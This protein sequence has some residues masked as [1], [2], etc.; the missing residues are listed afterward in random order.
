MHKYHIPNEQM[1][2]TKWEYSTNWR[3]EDVHEYCQHICW[4]PRIYEEKRH[5]CMSLYVCGARQE[6]SRETSVWLRPLLS[7]PIRGNGQNKALWKH[8]EWNQDFY[9]HLWDNWGVFGAKAMQ[10]YSTRIQN[11]INGEQ[12]QH[13]M[14]PLIKSHVCLGTVLSSRYHCHL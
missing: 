4:V 2:K 11:C 6:H 13:N 3:M 5:P 9:W 1:K 7:K 12:K 10:N 14:S 8:R